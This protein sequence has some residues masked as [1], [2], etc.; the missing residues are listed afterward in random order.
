M[1][2]VLASTSICFDVSVFEFF[3]TLC[4]GG[5]VV[6]VDNALSL[7]ADP[8][9]VTM[10]SSVPS[11]ARALVEAGALPRSTRVVCLGGEAVTG[12]LVDDLYAT[13]HVEAVVNCYGPTEDTTYSTFA[14]LQP[15]EQ[16]P[17]I[18]A[19]LPHG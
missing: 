6:V 14:V 19:L 5:T 2:R 16:P 3:A 1:S 11:A 12:S 17:P 10:I 4:T 13:G 8:P 15:A 7:L 9:A 18:G